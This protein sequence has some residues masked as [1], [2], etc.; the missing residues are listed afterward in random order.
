MTILT[1]QI[2]HSMGLFYFATSLRGL[3]YLNEI[4]SNDLLKTMMQ[5]IFIMLLNNDDTVMDLR[6]D[7]LRWDLSNDIDCLSQLFSFMSLPI[8]SHVYDKQNLFLSVMM[9]VHYLS[10]SYHLN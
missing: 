8:L 5:E 6:V 4:Y 10:I 3:Q 7:T 1:A 2:G 9:C